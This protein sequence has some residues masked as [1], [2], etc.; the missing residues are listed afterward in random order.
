MFK[1]VY[2]LALSSR[3]YKQDERASSALI[4]FSAAT[5]LSSTVASTF[6]AK[7]QLSA[8]RNNHHQSGDTYE[9]LVEDHLEYQPYCS[10][11]SCKSIM[12][13]KLLA[14]K[15]LPAQILDGRV[16]RRLIRARTL[17]P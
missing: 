4:F 12:V 7:S 11:C 14:K 9:L 3:Y 13:M 2:T 6:P 17:H 16:G 5:E 10:I 1:Y 8:G 15:M